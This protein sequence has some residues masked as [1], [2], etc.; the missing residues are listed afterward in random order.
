MAFLSDFM[1]VDCGQESILHIDESSLKLNKLEINANSLS[2]M[3]TQR[4]KVLITNSKISGELGFTSTYYNLYYKDS[5]IFSINVENSELMNQPSDLDFKI[6]DYKQ[7]VLCELSFN[8]NKVS[9]WNG[10]FRFYG[11]IVSFKRNRIL[12]N[13]YFS[14]MFKGFDDCLI[15]QNTFVNNSLSSYFLQIFSYTGYRLDYYFKLNSFLIFQS[16]PDSSIT[17]LNN[18]FMGNRIN[19]I[20]NSFI[21]FNSM[22]FSESS[23]NVS[24]KN[25]VFKN[26]EIN[27]EII[28]F[29]ANCEQID[30][31]YNYWSNRGLTEIFDVIFTSNK[32]DFYGFYSNSYYYY[33]KLEKNKDI[34]LDSFILDI[35]SDGK[36]RFFYIL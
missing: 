32:T 20:E 36:I 13:P 5:A 15:E 25:N 7:L 28:I 17:L 24:L 3:D 34:K 19:N 12:N 29:S 23:N 31:G 10:L 27:F 1:F 26:P 30:F 16:S 22:V 6:C 21:S 11:K 35:N 33:N 14:F 4:V 8:D 2:L 18:S 9:N